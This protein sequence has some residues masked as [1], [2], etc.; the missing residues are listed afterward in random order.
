MT[1]LKFHKQS[2]RLAN[3]AQLARR[4]GNIVESK[5]LYL[6]AALDEIRALLL[7]D[8]SKKRTIGTATVNAATLLSKSD[9]ISEM[10]NFITKQLKT[11]DLP[12]FAIAKLREL[13]KRGE[14]RN[15]SRN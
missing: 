14:A 12:D 9:H 11:E 3:D 15:G 13:F 8:K 4:R 10:T 5:S 1:C 7:M 6:T 2:E